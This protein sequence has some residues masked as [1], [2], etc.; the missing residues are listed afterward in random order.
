[1]YYRSNNIMVYLSPDEDGKLLLQQSL[2]FQQT[3]GM[4]VFIYS[5]NDKSPFFKRILRYE[6]TRHV[7][8]F[9]L[10]KFIQNVI[11]AKSL[12]HFSYRIKTGKRLPLLISQSNSGGY[13]FMIVDKS[14]SESALKPGEIDKLISHSYCPIM[15][16][17]KNYFLKEVKKIVIPV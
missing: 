15:A 4:R 3:L 7:D 6:K 1:M 8:S 17:H 14:D 13:E 9:I 10:Q 2:F 12:E 16:V 11:P 5:I